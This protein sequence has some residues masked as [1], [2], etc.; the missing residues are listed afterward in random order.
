MRFI[1]SMLVSSSSYNPQLTFSRFQCFLA[2]FAFLWCVLR[3][4]FKNLNRVFKNAVLNIAL[5]FWCGRGS[6]V[7]RGE[8][9]W[10]VGGVEKV[11]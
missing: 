6:G 4:R 2:S 9:L 5:C 8:K 3:V 10:L 7:I 1:L 11:G